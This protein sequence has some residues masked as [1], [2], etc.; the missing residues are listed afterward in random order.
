MGVIHADVG[1]GLRHLKS[2]IR[3]VGIDWISAS[4]FIHRKEGRA[5]HRAFLNPEGE[6]D[7]VLL[8]E[9]MNLFADLTRMSRVLVAPLIVEGI[10]S[11]PCTV[12]GYFSK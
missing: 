1:I 12:V 4:S 11:A 5:A 9:D 8:V 10:D 3:A 7:P 6:G 2:S